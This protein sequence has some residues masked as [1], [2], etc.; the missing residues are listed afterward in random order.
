MVFKNYLL[1]SIIKKRVWIKDPEPKNG[2]DAL[3][4]SYNPTVGTA[5]HWG[6]AQ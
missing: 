6:V 4:S 2:K 1:W 5:Q 3:K